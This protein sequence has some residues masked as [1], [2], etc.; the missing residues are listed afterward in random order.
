MIK[1]PKNSFHIRDQ[2]E[3]IMFEKELNKLIAT[4][5]MY[6]FVKIDLYLACKL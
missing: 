2:S 1:N 5:D 6:L 4:E 3:N